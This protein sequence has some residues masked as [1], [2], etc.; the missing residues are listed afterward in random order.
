MLIEQ[1]RIS[2][3]INDHETRRAGRT[4]VSRDGQRHALRLE[5]ALQRSNVVEL[6]ERLCV[7]IPS[8]IE[9][10]GVALEHALKETDDGV[11]ILEDLPSFRCVAGEGCEAKLFVEA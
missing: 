3:R 4:L 7:L 11:P 8:R 1:N 2:V 6:A 5:A 10:Q 9:R